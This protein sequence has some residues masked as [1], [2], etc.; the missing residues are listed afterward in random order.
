MLRKKTNVIKT[1]KADLVDHVQTF[2]SGIE[3]LNGICFP[4]LLGQET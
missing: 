3:I 1:P 2:K 4:R